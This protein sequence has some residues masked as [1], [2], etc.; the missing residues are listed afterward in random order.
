HQP[1]EIQPIPGVNG[2]ALKFIGVVESDQNLGEYVQFAGMTLG[3]PTVEDSAFAATLFAISRTGDLYALT[4]DEGD[5]EDPDDTSVVKNGIFVDAETSVT[6][7]GVTDISGLAFSTLDYNMWHITQRRAD[8]DGHDINETYDYSRVDRPNDPLPGGGASYYFG[9]E[10]A[11]NYNAPGGAYGSLVSGA[12][13]LAQYTK[14]DAPTL[15]FDYFLDIGQYDTARVFASTDGVNWEVLGAT[16]ANPQGNL[17]DTNGQWLQTHIAPPE[18]PWQID[19]AN[20]LIVYY[21][22]LADFAGEDEVYL[23]FDFTT[24]GDMNVG[25]TDNELDTTGA[26]LNALDGDL[27]EDGDTLIVDS[28]LFEFDMGVALRLPNVAGDYIPDGETFT[29]SGLDEFGDP[30]VLGTFEFD[31]DGTTEPGNFAI[32]LEN[33]QNT[34]QVAVKVAAVV[35][36]ILSGTGVFADFYENRVMLNGAVEVEQSPDATVETEGD[37]YGNYFGTPI[38]IDSRMSAEEVAVVMGAT[39]DAVFAGGQK[40]FEVQGSIVRMIHHP[41]E[42]S[43]PL[44]Y[45]NSLPG[46]EGGDFNSITRGQDNNHEGFYIDNIVIG[47]AERGEMITQAPANTTTFTTEHLDTVISTGYYQLQIRGAS[48]YAI[49]GYDWNNDPWLDLDRSFDINDRFDETYTLTVL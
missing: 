9:Y 36:K 28:V 25:D 7:P 27:I 31:K 41:V 10:D 30:I 13:S 2:A 18:D 43:G 34:T 47:F 32:S 22:S 3:P 48:E 6:V 40:S 39:F 38:S 42:F 21:W 17:L 15:Y 4:V 29:V 24:A 45:S 11:G 37:G 46:D 16:L 8:D 5:P 19:T 12:F 49:F 44:P 1:N 26:F 35:N 20:N 33:G 23:R 14:A